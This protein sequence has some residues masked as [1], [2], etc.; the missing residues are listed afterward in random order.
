MKV[1][2]PAGQVGV[3]VK[4]SFLPQGGDDSRKGSLRG[5]G[6]CSQGR[7]RRDRGRERNQLCPPQVQLIQMNQLPKAKDTF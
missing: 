7:E 6:G 2:S 3:R 4:L 5:R 1:W